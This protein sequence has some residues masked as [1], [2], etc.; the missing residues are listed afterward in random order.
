MPKCINIKCDSSTIKTISVYKFHDIFECMECRNW[1]F[2]KI[3][4]CCRNPFL[5][6]AKDDKF[7]KN[8]RA[9]YQCIN[10]GGCVNRNKALSPNDSEAEFENSRFEEWQ[11]ERSEEW[12]QLSESKK[13]F[14][15]FNS[16]YY[17]Y[18]VYLSSYEWKCKRKLVLARD[19]NLC[20]E[21]RVKP[22]D[23][24]HHLTYKNLF[25][26]PLEDLQ[27]LCQTCHSNK[28]GKS[29]PEF[30]SKEHEISN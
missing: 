27:S 23:E 28:H 20:Q 3:E 19:N 11:R 16:P 25:D 24:I 2:K 7:P 17:K 13:H 12:K 9:Y 22:A 15:Y 29:L 21:C 14:K 1:T 10:C 8:P 5:V 6:I 18:Q 26:E 4:D 30:V